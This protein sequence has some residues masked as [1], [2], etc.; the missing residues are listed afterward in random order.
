[1]R[2]ARIFAEATELRGIAGG[3]GQ[4]KNGRCGREWQAPIAGGG[5]GRCQSG[6]SLRGLD[7]GLGAVGEVTSLEAGPEKFDR[8]DL[9]SMGEQPLD[10]ES[11]L[12]SQQLRGHHPG[13]GEPDAHPRAGSPAGCRCAAAVL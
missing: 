13:C 8:V 1:M 12:L 3:K 10:G 9:G 11:A 6:Q 2:T 7:G 5:R 4:K